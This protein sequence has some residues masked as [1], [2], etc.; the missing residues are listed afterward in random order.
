MELLR[1]ALK[2]RILPFRL[3]HDV[4][5]V[6]T[7]YIR[8]DAFTPEELGIVI[9]VVRDVTDVQNPHVRTPLILMDPPHSPFSVISFL[10]MNRTGLVKQICSKWYSRNQV[11]T[12]W[13]EWRWLN[14]G[15]Y[16]S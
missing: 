5:I 12:S 14:A 6:I 7:E 15:E 4:G 8:V 13:C 10:L 9:R 3:T 1:L 11:S 2:L 16:A